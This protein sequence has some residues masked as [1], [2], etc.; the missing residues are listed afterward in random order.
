[1]SKTKISDYLNDRSL[2]LTDFPVYIE[3][4][5]NHENKRYLY[6]IYFKSPYSF[7]IT[8]PFS[9][10]IRISKNTA[11]MYINKKMIMDI[12]SAFYN[13]PYIKHINKKIKVRYEYYV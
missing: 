9:N 5:I 8:N 11:C 10:L 7:T 3:V 6:R 1:M 2:Y 12:I 13:L 4:E